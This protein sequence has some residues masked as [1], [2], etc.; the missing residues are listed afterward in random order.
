MIVELG[1]YALILALFL[2]LLQSV[3]PLLGAQRKKQAWM[4]LGHQAATSFFWLV[5]IAFLSLLHA[6]ALTDLSVRVVAEH[7]HT[8]KPLLYK[9]SA[10]WGHHEGSMLL[11]LWMLAFWAALVAEA[12]KNMPQDFKARVL[13]IMGMISACFCAFILFTSNPFARLDPPAPEGLDLNPLLQ[14]LL[15][16]IHPPVLYAGYVGFAVAFSFAVAALIEGK[17]DRAFAAVLKPWALAAWGFLTVGIAL[18]SFWAYYELGWGGFWFWDPVENASLLPWLA[19]LALLHSLAVL[20]KRDGL[21]GWTVFLALLSF[22]FSLLGTFLVRSGVLTSVHAFASDPAR[23]IFILG[24]LTLCTGGAFLLYGF[25]AAALQGGSSFGATSRDSAILLNNVFLFSFAACVFMGTLYPIFLSALDLGSVS[26]GGPYYV[27]VLMPLLLPFAL[28]MGVSPRLAWKENA[29]ASMLKKF[30]PPLAGT[31]GLAAGIYLLPQEKT[32]V[33]V[34]GFIAA[35]WIFFATLHDLLLKTRYF[36]SWRPL[37]LSFYG[38][39]A[40]HLGFALLVAGAVAATQMNEE[41]ILWMQPRDQAEIGGRKAVLL[42]VE[43]GLGENYNADRAIFIIRPEKDGT[44]YS[45]MMPEKR[46]YPAAQK[47][48]SEAAL[49]ASGFDILYIVL[50]DADENDAARRVVRMYYHPLVLLVFLGGG[51]M[52]FGGFIA[53]LDRRRVRAA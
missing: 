35:G 32:A 6:F 30:L 45:F 1:H 17:V 40:A 33:L 24:L 5:T 42:A 11:W 20:E 3:V 34:V 14:D 4:M 43:T 27:T 12:G 37:P 52:A 18:G 36:R 15:L 39:I 46:W 31:L 13:S 29:S 10:L 48:T 16:A 28:L 7:S 21:R 38:M 19:G 47:E 8:M 9:I 53:A 41:K 50:G 2:A 23:G 25:R 26:V 44:A 49:L 22:S 51:M